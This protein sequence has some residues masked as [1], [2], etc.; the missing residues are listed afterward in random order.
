MTDTTRSGSLERMSHI[1]D[2]GVV[3]VDADGRILLLGEGTRSFLGPPD[4]FPAT[5]AGVHAQIERELSRHSDSAGELTLDVQVGRDGEGSRLYVRVLRLGGAGREG[6]L[7]IF[8]KRRLLDALQA[9]LRLA[10]QMRRLHANYRQAAHDLRAPLNAIAL[11]LELV[12]QDVAD[13]AGGRLSRNGTKKRVEML[14]RE[15]TRLSRML[16]GLLAQS[17]PPRS[18]ARQL[19]LRPLL[20]EVIALVTPQAERLGIR[21]AL[22]V[23]PERV[24]VS[25]ARDQLKQGLLNLLMNAIEAMPQGGPLE[26]EL[27]CEGARAVVR[28]RD[29][30]TGIAARHLDRI[31]SLHFT[32]KPGGSGI[33]LFTT[34]AAIESMGGALTLRSEEGAGTTASIELPLASSASTREVSCSTS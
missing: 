19:G 1:E 10:S 14:R 30:G 34:R 33:G 28:I 2:G 4:A 20:R 9:D 32:T 12:R 29:R 23:P 11:N 7:A 3:M 5:W 13:C 25:A 22:Q 17:E 6:Y 26:I 18:A 27:G 15:V 16:G 31:F 8:T 24:A 21:I